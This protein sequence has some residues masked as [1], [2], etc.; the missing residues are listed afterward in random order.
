MELLPYSA[1][2][3]PEKAPEL[4]DLEAALFAVLNRVHSSPP[5]VLA[6]CNLTL[7]LC[8]RM[9]SM[10]ASFTGTTLDQILSLTSKGIKSAQAILD[11]G[12]PW[13][14]MANIPFQIVCMLLA[15]DTISSI[16][17]LKDA[18]GCLSNVTKVYNTDA[19]REALNTA[20]LLILL[21]QRWKE[22][23]ASDL[24]EILK[25]YPAV[26][27]QEA[28]N[29][30]LSQQPED[31]RWLNSLTGD[32]SSLDYSDF[33]RILFPTLFQNTYNGI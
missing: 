9:Q 27:L 24:N 23:C 18:M 16:A 21:H 20:S 19:T 14:H 15:I 17:Q 4:S 10:N 29:E 33:D 30:T 26:S 8:R 32:L 7:C 13:H 2:L 25:L 31:V 12:A 28:P 6:Q 11:D 1:E 5:S 22:K 3:D